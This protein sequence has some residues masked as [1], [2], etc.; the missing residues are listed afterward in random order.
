MALNPKQ[1]RFVRE[2]LINP[3]ATQAA[4]KAGYSAKTA[5]QI[6]SALLTNIDVSA[7][8]EKGQQKHLAK[9]D[10]TAERVL[11]ELALIGFSNMQDYMRVGSDGDPYLDFSGLT[12]EQ[13]A[14]LAEVTVED[15]TAGRGEDARDVR[16]VKFKLCDKRAALVDIGKHLG[17]FKERV[18]HDLSPD[19]KFILQGAPP[20]TDES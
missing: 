19:V 12:R 7:A 3:N 11:S 1:K 20:K 2:Y 18:E 4:I 9:L 16:R 17:M 15:F 14:A 13:A 8:I 5:K 6:G 10:I